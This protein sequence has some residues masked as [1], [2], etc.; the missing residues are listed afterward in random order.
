MVVI[1]PGEPQAFAGRAAAWLNEE[2]LSDLL[3]DCSGGE[4]ARFF[5]DASGGMPIL[6]QLPE[7]RDEANGD[8]SAGSPVTRM[9]EL[10]AGTFA[11]N[12]SQLAQVCRVT[13]ATLYGW[14]RG[15]T[16]RQDAL[17]RIARLHRAAQDWQRSGFP[18]PV[19]SLQLPMMQGKSLL[20]LLSAEPLDFDAIHFLGSRLALGEAATPP[21]GLTD[22]FR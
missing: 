12:Q 14:Q 10:I 5:S 4:L 22:P 8:H 3:L 17:R 20:V 16:P 15:T 2:A 19:A 6:Q 13:R 18:E 1:E 11:I 21:A 9:L 7:F